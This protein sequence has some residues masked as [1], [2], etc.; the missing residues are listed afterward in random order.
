VPRLPDLRRED[1]D[2]EQLAVYDLVCNARGAESLNAGG[3]LVGPFNSFVH[4]P[5]AGS[6]LLEFMNALHFRSSLPIQ[7]TELAILT[8]GA[9]WQAEFE[10]YAHARRARESGVADS[11]IEAIGDGRVPDFANEGDRVVHAL[12]RKLVESGRIDDDVYDEAVR[13]LG[14]AGVVELVCVAGCYTLISFILNGF[15]VQLPQGVPT[16]WPVAR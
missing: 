3:G 7:T 8:V 4:A 15:D 9:H 12:V 10:W 5:V 13:H 14:H 11:V 1:L 2:P 6:R 16:Q